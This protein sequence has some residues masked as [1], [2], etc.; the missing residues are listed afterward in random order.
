MV[1]ADTSI[2]IA[3]HGPIDCNSGRHVLSIAKELASFG[4]GITLCVPAR[5]TDIS[6]T[7]HGFK[8]YTFH[9]Y[10]HLPDVQ[11]PSFVYFWTPRMIMLNFY[12]A[13][14]VRFMKK[15]PYVVHLEDNERWL[16]VK[17]T[18]VTEFEYDEILEGRRSFDTHANLSHPFYSKNFINSAAGITALVDTLLEDLSAEQQKTVFWPGYDKIFEDY[19]YTNRLILRN[20]LGIYTNTYLTAYTGNVHASNVDEVRSLYRAVARVNRMGLSLKL[21]RTGIDFVGLQSQSEDC[22]LY[23]H[24]VDLGLQPLER[25]PAIMQAADIL[26]QPGCADDW[27]RYR[28][29]SK[30]PEFL[31]SCR[32]VVLPRANIGTVLEHTKNALVYDTVTT[33][34]IVQAFLEY[35]PQKDTLDKIGVRGGVFARRELSWKKAGTKIANLFAELTTA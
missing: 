25:L 29:P 23:E 3:C 35:L 5:S 21:L 34:T 16:F 13:L 4:F 24:A 10:L 22:D 7:D 8:L 1:L 30:L 6:F 2:C 14:C 18:K 33:D 15:I 11:S 26:V 19:S 20:K 31:V 9:E 17:S 27:N 28:V 12:E 32:P